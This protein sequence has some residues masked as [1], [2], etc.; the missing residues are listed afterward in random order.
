MK[1]IYK[2]FEEA[3]NESAVKYDRRKD[4]M[5]TIIMIQNYFNIHF[6]SS[7]FQNVHQNNTRISNEASQPDNP[8]PSREENN[9]TQPSCKVYRTRA[10]Q[11]PRDPTNSIQVT[12]PS[13]IKDI[14]S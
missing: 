14:H 10:A 9:K 7:G 11:Q 12:T 8:R 5:K 6:G 3:P 4:E 1:N 2:I 13:T